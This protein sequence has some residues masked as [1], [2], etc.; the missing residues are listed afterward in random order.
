M[1]I[2]MTKAKILSVAGWTTLVSYIALCVWV[3][4]EGC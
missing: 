2:N 1:K 4:I 3:I